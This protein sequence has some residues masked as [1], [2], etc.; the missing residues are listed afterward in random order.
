MTP[1][2]WITL[3]LH[4]SIDLDGSYGPQC[5]DS[6]RS[7]LRTCYP[8]TDLAGNAADNIGGAPRG[9]RWIANGPYNAPGLGSV[10]FWNRNVTALSIGPFGH[11]AIALAADRFALVTADQNWLGIP[12]VELVAHGYVGIAGWWER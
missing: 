8:G 1:M 9:W 11:V 12:R 6:A 10:V 5:V 3:N 7:F 2:Q 4:R